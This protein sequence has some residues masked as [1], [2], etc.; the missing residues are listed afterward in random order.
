[1]IWKVPQ[2]WLDGECWIIG[3]GPSMPRQFGVP[4]ETIRAVTLKQQK[5]DAYSQYLAPLHSRHTIGINNAYMIGDWIDA[6]FFGDCAWYVMH[7]IPLANWP[8]LKVTCCTRF[9]NKQE[10]NCDGIKYL[11]KDKARSYGISQDPSTVAWNFNSGAAA[12]SLAAHLG[13]RRIILLGF[14]MKLDD[15]HVSHWFGTHADIRRGGKVP[16]PPFARHL[17]GFPNIAEDATKRGIEIL[18][19]SPDSAIT[20]FPKVQVKDIL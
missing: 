3:G 15:K 11:A 9:A 7:R 20:V 17:K 5:A 1:M 2:L 18:N 6:L 10:A 16:T 13:V 4:E 19:A 14:D 8:K 12:I